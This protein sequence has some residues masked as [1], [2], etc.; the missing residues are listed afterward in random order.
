MLLSQSE[1]GQ[2]DSHIAKIDN[3]LVHGPSPGHKDSPHGE[4]FCFW[5]QS[6]FQAMLRLLSLKT[7][8]DALSLKLVITISRA[9]STSIF[10]QVFW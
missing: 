4:V 9:M 1:L 8:G 10:T 6:N 3:S 5:E 7:I 2:Q